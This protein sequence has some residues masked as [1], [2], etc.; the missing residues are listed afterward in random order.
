VFVVI[1]TSCQVFPAAQLPFTAKEKGS[2]IIEI[3][4]EPT[5]VSEIADISLR[6][7]ATEGME[8]VFNII[9]NCQ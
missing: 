6:K 7:K 3:N 2:K 4:P 1:G 5:P 9:I 8:D